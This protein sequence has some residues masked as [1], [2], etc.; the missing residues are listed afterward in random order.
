MLVA[1]ANLFDGTFRNQIEQAS[2]AR[3]LDR[4][5]RTLSIADPLV[6]AENVAPTTNVWGCTAAV[7]PASGR[8]IDLFML[9]LL[10][11]PAVVR[12]SRRA[13]RRPSRLCTDKFHKV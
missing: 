9:V 13:T 1:D 8:G 4:S 2:L 10:G 6:I 12:G 3:G 7:G 5:S 11:L